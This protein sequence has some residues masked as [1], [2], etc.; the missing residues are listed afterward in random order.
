MLGSGKGERTVAGAGPVDHADVLV[1]VA[2]AMDVEKARG[3]QGAGAGFGRGRPIANEF[4]VE[5]A[6]LFGLAQGGG[7]RVFVELDVAAEGKPFVEL[8]MMD[9]EDAILMDDKNRDGEINLIVYVSHG[10]G[11]LAMAAGGVKPSLWIG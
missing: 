6:F 3:D 7:F 10:S 8:A 4:D 9:E 2:D 11:I 1:R 5:T